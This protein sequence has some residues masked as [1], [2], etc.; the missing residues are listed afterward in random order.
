[1]HWRCSN[2]IGSYVE[3]SDGRV[4]S[5]DDL[6]FDDRHWTIRWAVID[7]GTWLSSRK[8]LLPPSQFRR[9][10]A[11]LWQFRVDLDREHVRASPKLDT[12]LPV[13]RQ[14]ETEIYKHYTW[15]PYWHGSDATPFGG[16][17]P[18]TTAT[19]EPSPGILRDVDERPSGDPH[20]RSIKEVTG[21]YI[22]ATDKPIGH[23][24]DFLLA[25]DHW[26]ITY[27]V[28]DT[29]NWWPGRK[30]IVSPDWAQMISWSEHSVQLGL[31]RNQVQNSPTFNPD[32]PITREYE[33][34][35]WGYYGFPPL[36]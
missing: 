7:T 23:V 30:V 34:R 13:S 11:S 29:S 35:L 8:V 22:H 4:G 1:M 9:P 32:S 27:L 36:T 31:S 5:I 15:R 10:D 28:V 6:L 2:I 20:L 33:H 26:K 3:A 18:A 19:I 25:A 12:D 17:P 14:M 24:E 16:I 21:Y